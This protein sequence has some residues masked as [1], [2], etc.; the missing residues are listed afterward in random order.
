MRMGLRKIQILSK[1][2]S[3][4]CKNVCMVTEWCTWVQKSATLL[5]RVTRLCR[6]KGWCELQGC[7]KDFLGREENLGR[8]SS[9]SKGME[10]W[11]ELTALQELVSKSGHLCLRLTGGNPREYWGEVGKKIVCC[12]KEIVHYA[13]GLTSGNSQL[14]F[15]FGNVTGGRLEG[16]WK[17]KRE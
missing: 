9:I 2:W 4:M 17:W 10:T 6:G 16:K 11:K 3:E 7:C 14:R 8:S 12:T 15:V 13:V 5:G 1:A